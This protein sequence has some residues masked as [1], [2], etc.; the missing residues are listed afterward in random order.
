MKIQF[1]SL[2]YLR[3]Q[4]FSI[5]LDS[6]LDQNSGNLDCYEISIHAKLF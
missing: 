6:R 5:R 3:S 2:E 1:L 4:V